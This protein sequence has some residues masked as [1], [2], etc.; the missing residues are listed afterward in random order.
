MKTQCDVHTSNAEDIERE[1]ECLVCC[2]ARTTSFTYR[3]I[4][5]RNLHIVPGF[6]F[7]G[8][9]RKYAC[10]C[11]P[12][13]P[14]HEPKSKSW[15]SS[16][17]KKFLPNSSNLRDRSVTELVSPLLSLRLLH[18]PTVNL[19]NI[20]QVILKHYVTMYTSGNVQEYKCISIK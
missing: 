19:S 5:S 8:T 16:M 1:G 10:W 4:T 17:V 9:S 13:L 18:V 7:Y 6:I 2:Q 20:K 3:S 14:T 15:A 11:W 12:R